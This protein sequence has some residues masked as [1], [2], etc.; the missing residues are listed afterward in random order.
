MR[1]GRTL[2][3]CSRC[4]K[5]V[6]LKRCS[7][8]S[9]SF[10]WVYVVDLAPAGTARRQKSKGGFATKSA[11]LAAMAELQTSKA[12]GSYIEASKQT[13][14]AYLTEWLAGIRGQVRGGTFASYQLNSR[15]LEPILGRIALQQLT[16]NEVKAAY[17]KLAESGGSNGSKLSSKTVHNCHLTL[18]KALGDAVE[19]RLLPFNPA[20]AA[21]KLQ[22][23]R[24]EMLTWSAEE[25]R[26]FLTGCETSDN[27]PLWRLASHTGMRRGEVLGLRWRDVDLEAS[28]LSV[29][30]QLVRNGAKVGFGPPKTAKGRRSL[31]LD[32]GTVEILK[33]HRDSQHKGRWKLGAAYGDLDLVFARNDGSPLDPDVVTAQFD[34]QLVKLG[35]RRIRLH[36]LRHT[37]ATLGLAAGIH[38]KVM[39]ERLGHSSIAVTL[40]LYSHVVPAM[41]EDAA[42]RIAAVV[43]SS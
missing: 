9:E 23:D 33:A 19:D 28:R 20:D 5:R 43:A 39:Q 32:A 37:H 24:P 13:L 3:R 16:R 18:R 30:Q 11:A 42:S 38:P 7:C 27:H 12:N 21:H 15:R 29:R 41:Q 10:S 26:T 17:L 8:G 36:D 40:D 6:E 31:A 2:K 4:G 14:S 25:L 22:G 34:R 1:A 35:I